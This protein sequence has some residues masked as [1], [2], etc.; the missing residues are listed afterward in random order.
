[1]VQIG[2]A[3]ARPGKLLKGR[4]LDSAKPWEVRPVLG[5]GNVTCGNRSHVLENQ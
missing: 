1:M 5:P 4:N 3:E 2:G